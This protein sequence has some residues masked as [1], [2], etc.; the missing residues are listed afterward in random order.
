VLLALLLGGGAALLLVLLASTGWLASLGGTPEGA[1][2][3]RMEASPRFRDGRFVNTHPFSMFTGGSSSWDVTREWLASRFDAGRN[4]TAPLPV[5]DP[6]PAWRTPPASGLRV[7]WLG[8]S[9]LLVELDGARILTDPV[10]GERASP[11]TLV[12]PGRF[13][14]PPAPLADLPPL[15]AVVLSHDHYDHLDMPTIRTLART[16]EVPFFV[17]LGLGAHLEAWGVPA[18]RI[19]ELDWWQEAAVPGTA[20]GK[21]K[22]VTVTATPAQHFSG[23]GLTNR[24]STLWASWV[25][26]S[27]QH[28]VFFSGDTGLTPELEQV[29]QR[30]GPFDLVMLEVGAFHRTWSAV[31][32]GPEGALEAHRLLGG[33]PLLPIHWSTFDLGMHAWEEPAETLARLAPQ[34]GVPLLTPRLGVPL[35]PRPP[36]PTTAWWRTVEGAAPGPSA[37]ARTTP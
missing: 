20:G 1:R 30:L 22:G 13:H 23:R 3:A 5:E 32:L 10:W 36:P 2:R 9:T 29:G 8:H 4:P 24:F 17:P 16:T 33:G 7:T 12:G 6:R 19:T 21:A 34:R 28:R 35:E 26:R 15:D 14:P 27:G 25:L 11:S 37:Q 18:H 31:H